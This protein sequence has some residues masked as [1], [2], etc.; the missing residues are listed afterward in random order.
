MTK[1]INISYLKMIWNNALT[2]K[3]RL[4]SELQNAHSMAENAREAYVL[5]QAAEVSHTEGEER[6]LLDGEL[7]HMG[8][9]H[10]C[11]RS[12]DEGQVLQE[13]WVVFD[14]SVLNTPWQKFLPIVVA[15]GKEWIILNSRTKRPLP[16]AIADPYNLSC[17][18]PR[19]Y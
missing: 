11:I 8:D 1:E 14:K 2:F 13:N 19:R 3:D 12:G 7:I 5:A 10:Q 15:T 16:K 17:F 4:Y 9:E 18:G 6:P